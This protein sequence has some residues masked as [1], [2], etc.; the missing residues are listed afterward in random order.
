MRIDSHCSRQE[1][2]ARWLKPVKLVP[3]SKLGMGKCLGV[4]KTVAFARST[5]VHPLPLMRQPADAFG[6]RGGAVWAL[7]RRR[8]G[9]AGLVSSRL[10]ILA[11]LPPG[12][13]VCSDRP[14]DLISVPRCGP[15]AVVAG[16]VNPDHLSPELL[17]VGPAS[18]RG[19][20][21]GL[22][23]PPQHP[24]ARGARGEAGYITR[25]IAWGR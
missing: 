7:K 21:H 14:R 8:K 2:P 5:Q 6:S 13:I 12:G 1:V 22:L 20:S 11:P 25:S 3:N 18:S 4:K 16:E 23:G 19:S 17:C 15:R 9:I 10:S 24:R